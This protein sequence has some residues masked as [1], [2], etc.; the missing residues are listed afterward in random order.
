MIKGRGNVL[1]IPVADAVV[2]EV[3]H[4]GEDGT[5]DS[6]KRIN[7]LLLSPSEE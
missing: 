6:T 7:I 2:A 3:L 1:K 4:S 5:R